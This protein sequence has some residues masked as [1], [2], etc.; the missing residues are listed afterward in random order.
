MPI[1]A[2]K[3]VFPEYTIPRDILDLAAYAEGQDRAE[4]FGSIFVNEDNSCN[5]HFKNGGYIPVADF[6]TNPGWF[7]FARGFISRG[8]AV[9]VRRDNQTYSIG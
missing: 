7:D 2:L 5:L 8:G 4:Q 1:V 9:N 6:T 3:Y